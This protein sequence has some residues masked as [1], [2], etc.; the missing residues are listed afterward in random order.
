[1]K[2]CLSMYGLLLPPGVKGL[3]DV[4]EVFKEKSDEIRS[5]PPTVFFEKAVLKIFGKFI[6]SHLGIL[7][8]GD[9]VE[10]KLCL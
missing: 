6:E 5:V 10:Y 3:K 4:L 7:K 2:V 1:M 8:A 9:Y